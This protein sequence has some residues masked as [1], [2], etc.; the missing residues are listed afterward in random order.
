MINFRTLFFHSGVQTS[1][2]QALHS[3]AELGP[4]RLWEVHAQGQP[5]CEGAFRTLFG[6]MRTSLQSF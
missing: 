5:G 6:W 2:K 3:M 4:H 1:Q